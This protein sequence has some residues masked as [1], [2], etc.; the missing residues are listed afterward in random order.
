MHLLLIFFILQFINIL[1]NSIEIIEVDND[2]D[3]Y[4]N[5]SNCY[6]NSGLCNLR[7]AWN[8]CNLLNTNLCEI[9]LPIKQIIY[10]NCSIGTLYL[11]ENINIDINGQGSRILPTGKSSTSFISTLSNS[12]INLYNVTV[13]N[14][15]SI[16]YQDND[17]NDDKD[18]IHQSMLLS[19]VYNNDYVYNDD[20]SYIDDNNDHDNFIFSITSTII[21]NK[22]RFSFS[23][24]IFESNNGASGG[25]LSIIESIG[26]ISNCI[27]L[28]NSASNGG[29]LWLE[30]SNITMYDNKWSDNSANN[31][32]VIFCNL[33]SLL[34]I[35]NEFYNNNVTNNGGVVYQ[36]AS[37]VIIKNST[38][39]YN[40]AYYN[41]E[42]E[43]Q[44]TY[45]GMGGVLY[46]NQTSNGLIDN[47][48]NSIIIY[49]SLISNNI[50]GISGSAVYYSGTSYSLFDNTVFD[51][52]EVVF[53]SSGGCLCIFNSDYFRIFNSNFTNNTSNNVGSMKIESSSNIYIFNSNFIGNT[54]KF[55]QD[56]SRYYYGYYDA[57]YG[58]GDVSDEK[59]FGEYSNIYFSNS[60]NITISSCIIKQNIA[61]SYGSISFD[62]N[63]SNIN[64]DSS[65]FEENIANQGISAGLYFGYKNINVTIDNCIF[66][67]NSAQQDG[68]AIYI[69]NYNQNIIVM[70]TIISNNIA[71]CGNGGGIYMNKNNINITLY[72]SI[73]TKN[74]AN[75]TNCQIESEFDAGRGGG[76]YYNANN[77]YL[78]IIGSEINNNIAINGGG[79]YLS[80]YNTNFV[81]MDELTYTNMRCFETSHPY[82]TADYGYFDANFPGASSIMFIFDSQTDISQGDSIGK[83]ILTIPNM[84]IFSFYFQIIF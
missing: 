3:S 40:K 79:L 32:G 50:A 37:S 20:Y 10:F 55:K 12:S 59:D 36:S 64:I 8:R 76:V 31:G 43:Q 26:N 19:Y 49:N 73:V 5:Y 56:A 68:T 22:S 9:I 29:S 84:I 62:V 25:V 6:S 53:G 45:L 63:N 13:S 47:T 30:S 7:S 61:A 71:I 67:K 27:F 38:F 60:D 1:I 57:Y 70:N 51:N 66:N 78:Y 39:M 33:S 46:S 52:N 4:G 54:A 83:Y 18:N 28:N 34:I 21:I 42:I 65:I 48:L 2:I 77:N 41:S 23:D 35:N 11:N 17:N 82:T 74:L 58:Y 24:L 80:N 15:G 81:I 14:F 44:E 69:N 72:K 16:I 75:S